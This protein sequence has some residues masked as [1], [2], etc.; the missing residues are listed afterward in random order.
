MTT[1]VR[2]GILGFVYTK[3]SLSIKFTNGDVYRYDES[4]ALSKVVLK[5]MILLARSGKGLNG[6]LNKQPQIRKSGYIDT[7]LRAG[8]FRPY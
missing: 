5:Q 6:F 4:E 3:T 7:T 1:Q 2:S 8:S